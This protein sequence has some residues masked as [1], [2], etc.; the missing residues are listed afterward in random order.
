ML[1]NGT[2][3]QTRAHARV[4]PPQRR[5]GAR[6]TAGSDRA[7]LVIRPSR[8]APPR[9]RTAPVYARAG[10][11]G[12]RLRRPCSGFGNHRDAPR[13]EC[14]PARMSPPRPR[15]AGRRGPRR[16]GEIAR[17]GKRSS[18]AAEW[19][20][21]PGR[22][23]GPPGAIARLVAR[24]RLG[25][26]VERGALLA[27]EGQHLRRAWAGA[28]RHGAGPAR[29]PRPGARA[30]PLT[31]PPRHGRRSLGGSVVNKGYR[32]RRSAASHSNIQIAA[33]RPSANAARV[34]GACRRRDGRSRNGYGQAAAP[35]RLRPWACARG[36]DARQ[37]PLRC[38]RS[39]AQQPASQD[40]GFAVAT[41]GACRCTRLG[42]GSARPSGPC[43]PPPPRPGGG[44]GDE[45]EASFCFGLSLSFPLPLPF[46]FSSCGGYS[47]RRIALRRGRALEGSRRL[48][49]RGG[50][51]RR[52]GLGLAA[53]PPA[54]R[55]RTLAYRQARRAPT[56]PRRSRRR[57][58]RGAPAASAGTTTAEGALLPW[59]ARQPPPGRACCSRCRLRP[60]LLHRSRPAAGPRPRRGS[61]RARGRL[62]ARAADAEHPPLGIRLADT[63]CARS[64]AHGPGELL[65]HRELL[66]PSGRGHQAGAGHEDTRLSVA[67]E[68][69]QAARL[70]FLGPPGGTGPEVALVEVGL[71]A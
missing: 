70:G 1:G 38:A 66:A 33:P 59:H 51:P 49:G 61:G 29:R 18:A 67:A 50:G 43:H 31:P 64:G 16:G 42:R 44:F 12:R 35:S 24:R 8:R 68:L 7:R 40:G 58:A 10:R 27:A 48:R 20:S 15:R 65:R 60:D 3:E 55:G 28:R 5:L 63:A 19:R 14:Q 2:G 9:R 62:R 30:Q 6:I 36:A 32:R 11:L 23:T 56:Q 47:A 54:R 13:A 41:S 4:P 71:G 39:R 22:E 25:S 21:A 46:G 37:L 69:P 45:S 17:A 34:S 57:G 53:A 26:D 52:R